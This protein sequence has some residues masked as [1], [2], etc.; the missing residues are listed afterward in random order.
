MLISLQLQPY[1]YKGFTMSKTITREK[2]KERLNDQS[3]MIIVEALPKTYYDTAHLPSALNIPHDEMRQKAPEMLPDKD[4]FIVLYC[5]STECQNS[6][7]ARDTLQE[8]GYTNA[9]EY[10]EGKQHWIEGNLPVESAP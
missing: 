2:I 8:M 9:F 3:P 7:I 1:R 4:A 5:A 10:V 6:T